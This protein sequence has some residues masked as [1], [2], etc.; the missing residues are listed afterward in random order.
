MPRLAINLA[1]ATDRFSGGTGTFVDGVL[2]GLAK[3]GDA[4]DVVI[5]ASPAAAGRDVWMRPGVAWHQEV[6]VEPAAS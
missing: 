6:V 1:S 2:D 4:V 5:V 3:M